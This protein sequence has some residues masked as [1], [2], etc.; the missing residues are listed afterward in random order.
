MTSWAASYHVVILII[1]EVHISVPLEYKLRK[2][3]I[4]LFMFVLLSFR[5]NLLKPTVHV[6]HQQFNIQQL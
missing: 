5:L 3:T 1:L 2:T 4:S 6:I